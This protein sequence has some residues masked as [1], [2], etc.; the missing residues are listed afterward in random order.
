[1]F[2]NYDENWPALGLAGA[3]LMQ[4]ADPQRLTL[5]YDPLTELLSIS[6]GPLNGA[7]RIVAQ[8]T[9]RYELA[10]VDR[11]EIWTPSTWGAPP[12]VFDDI[13]IT[14]TKAKEANGKKVF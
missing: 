10:T 1:V 11:F 5:T 4:S 6:H 3:H 9:G 13:V 7:Q 8:C 2:S 12:R 14:G